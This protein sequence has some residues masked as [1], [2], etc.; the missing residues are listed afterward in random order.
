MAFKTVVIFSKPKQPDVARVAGELEVW[1]RQRGVEATADP[2]AHLTTAPDLAVVV[3]GDGTLLAAARALGD[4]QIP[5][6]A[7]NYGSLGFLTEVT[8]EQMYPALEDVLAGRFV[9]DRRMMMDISVHQGASAVAEFRALNDAVINKGTL[10]RIIEVEARVDGH[11]VSS[12]RADGIIVCTPT[13]STAYNLSAGGPI[14]FPTMSA[15]IVTPICS[16]TLTN[17]PIVLPGDVLIEM[18]LKSQQE[19]VHLT[20]DGQVGLRLNPGDRLSVRKSRH[21]VELIAPADKNYF[22]VLRGKLKWG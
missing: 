19:E 2:P 14:T 21:T 5:I 12:F 22:D 6:L 13:G 17:R 20:V 4:H 7:I 3:G 9:S 11:Y 1:L 15:M 10:A 18:I 16:H 8:L